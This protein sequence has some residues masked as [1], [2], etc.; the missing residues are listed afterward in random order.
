MK[1][2]GYPRTLDCFAFR[3]AMTGFGS[4][5]RGAQ[6]R[7]NPDLCALRRAVPAA[8]ALAGHIDDTDEIVAPENVKRRPE[9]IQRLA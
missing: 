8:V 2:I 1:P 7:S 5:L 4:S 3:L 6:R 9:L